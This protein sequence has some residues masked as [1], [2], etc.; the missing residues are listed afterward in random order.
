MLLSLNVLL[1]RL[2][3]L[4]AC[5]IIRT[6]P[7]LRMSEVELLQRDSGVFVVLARND[8]LVACCSRCFQTQM[9]LRG[10]GLCARNTSAFA[11]Q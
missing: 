4:Y 11:L 9:S 2:G 3:I 5:F 1:V 7:G 8:I 10:R 6:M